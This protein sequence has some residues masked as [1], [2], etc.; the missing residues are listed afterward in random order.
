MRGLV[1][2]SRLEDADAMMAWASWLEDRGDGQHIVVCCGVLAH[3]ASAPK[4]LSYD[5]KTGHA[6][7]DNVLAAAASFDKGLGVTL[8]RG[9][10]LADAVAHLVEDGDFDIVALAANAT[11]KARFGEEDGLNKVLIQKLTCDV[12]LVEASVPPLGCSRILAAVEENEHSKGALLFARDLADRYGG[13]VSALMVGSDELDDAEAIIERRLDDTLKRWGLERSHVVL[14]R[15]LVAADVLEGICSEL[16]DEVQM[17]IVGHCR[18]KVM[19]KH[20]RLVQSL[21]LSAPALSI[22]TF[23]QGHSLSQRTRKWLS[24]GLD[25]LLPRLDRE[26]RVDLFERLHQGSRG[27]ADFIVLMAVATAIASLGLIQNSGAVVIGAMLVAPLMTPMIGA[28]MGLVQ[29]NLVMV[30]NAGRSILQ[31][32]LLALGIGFG[33]GLVTPVMPALNEELLARVNPN[34]LDLAIALLSGAAGA[35]ALA[36]PGLLAALPGVAIAAALVPP[37]ATVGVCMAVGQFSKAMGAALLFGTN[38]VCIIIASAGTLY[39]LGVRGKR[40]GAWRRLFVRRIWIL[41]VLAGVVFS[42][43]LSV[44]L[45][46]RV[47]E[48]TRLLESVVAQL[49]QDVGHIEIDKI[50]LIEDDE[51]TQVVLR[52]VSAQEPT[53]EW[54]QMAGVKI[55]EFLGRP[56]RL[57][58]VT[59]LAKEI[60]IP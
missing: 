1:V 12:L 37:I 39:C 10:D 25:A 17:L 4:E 11:S 43:P 13:K 48:D 16:D 36:R 42:V 5:E 46:G 29:G 32:F 22:A 9:P 44:S 18:Q 53:A 47:N 58:V 56:C 55:R 6:L 8:Y 50:E 60:L 15:T 33:L 26:G 51:G 24:V 7:V 30:E 41:L 23:C 35:Y 20:A 59:L 28:G 57:Q 3:Q 19:D 21:R 2:V 27:G 14:G 45:I 38:L 40:K 54:V 31:G 34:L 49:A 52:V